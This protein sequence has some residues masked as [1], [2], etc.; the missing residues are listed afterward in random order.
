MVVYTPAAR[1]WAAER[2]G[3]RVLIAQGLET[4]QLALDN[5]RIAIELRLVHSAPVSYPDEDGL[6]DLRRVTGTDDGY[7]DQVHAWRESY[8]ADL[9]TLV[10][11]FPDYCGLGWLL[12]RTRGMPRFGFTWV[13]A[14]CLDGLAL[15]HE[16]GH[17]LGANHRKDQLDSPGPGIFS[18]SA[19]WRWVGSD[20]RRYC[21][22]MSYTD[23]WAGEPVTRAPH[24]SNPDVE[25]LGATTGNPVDADNARTLGALR[26]VVGGYRPTRVRLL[27][28]ETT[29][30]GTTRPPPGV[31]PIRIGE[32]LRVEALPDPHFRHLGWSGDVSASPGP[33]TVALSDDETIVAEFE[34][35]IYAPLNLLGRSVVNRSLSRVEHIHVLAWEAHPD[36]VDIRGYRVYH[37]GPGQSWVLLSTVGAYDFSYWH[38]DVDTRVRHS[39]EVRAVNGEGREGPSPSLDMP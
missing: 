4:G 10:G 32:Q 28:I 20:S 22:V 19:G 25:H 16:M 1:D 33:L 35:I 29:P 39:Y 31:L 23:P 36:N 5:S 34:R 30:G 8:G 21:S 17:N 14:R 2:G 37:R 38:R 11:A 15:I 9:V 12:G 7:M 18:Y 13:A 26:Q 3:I 27:T 24:F 6:T